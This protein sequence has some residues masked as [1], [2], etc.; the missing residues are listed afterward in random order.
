MIGEPEICREAREARLP[1]TE[2]L[3]RQ[4]GSKSIP[5]SRDRLSRLRLEDA[6]QVVRRDRDTPCELDDAGARAL[7]E[8][9]SHLVDQ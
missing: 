7:D 6:A 9:L 5:V 8:R 1:G 3:E 2:P 4:S